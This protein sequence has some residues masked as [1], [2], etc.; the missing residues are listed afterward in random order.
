[1]SNVANNIRLCQYYIDTQT[2]ELFYL[3]NSFSHLTTEAISSSK[4]L[5]IINNV[6]G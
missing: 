4:G 5:D 1:M 2:R 6:F 3:K